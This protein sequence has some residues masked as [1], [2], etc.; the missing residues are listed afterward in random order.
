MQTLYSYADSKLDS[1]ID[2]LYT[3]FETHDAHEI[4]DIILEII[5]ELEGYK[6]IRDALRK[7]RNSG[8]RDVEAFINNLQEDFDEWDGMLY[9]LDAEITKL[10]TGKN[11]EKKAEENVLMTAKVVIQ[12]IR[13]GI[14]RKVREIND[15]L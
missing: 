7:A 13:R 6:R 8:L 3:V 11:E 12:E 4:D 1:V 9:D 2:E 14:L 5:K 15:R 10:F